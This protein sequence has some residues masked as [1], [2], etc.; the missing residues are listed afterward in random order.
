[1]SK[2]NTL[3]KTKRVYVRVSD[4]EHTMIKNK[5]INYPSISS[6][7]IDAVKAFNVK[8]GRNRL[9]ILIDFSNYAQSIEAEMSRVGNNLNQIT[10]EIHLYKY[11]GCDLPSVSELEEVLKENLELNSRILREIRRIGNKNS[12]V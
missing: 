4:E 5:S 7:M 2:T 10:H 8:Q 6:L 12:Q 3:G 1:M 11:G 9:D